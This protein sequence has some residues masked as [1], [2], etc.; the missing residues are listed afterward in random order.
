MFPICVIQYLQIRIQGKLRVSAH[1]L[2]TYQLHSLCSETTFAD[3]LVDLYLF[4]VPH[5]PEQIHKTYVIVVHNLELFFKGIQMTQI[6][7]LTLSCNSWNPPAARSAETVL[8][9]SDA[10]LAR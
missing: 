10:A 8:D 1:I 3:S 2:E 9:P 4:V 6:K 5:D 7:E